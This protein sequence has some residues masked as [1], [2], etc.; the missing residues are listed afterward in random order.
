MFETDGEKIIIRPDYEQKSEYDKM[1]EAVREFKE[2]HDTTA[3]VEDLYE[4]NYTLMFA[5]HIVDLPYNADVWDAVDTMLER[6]IRDW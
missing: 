5:G 4:R 1:L 2:W 6:T 3:G